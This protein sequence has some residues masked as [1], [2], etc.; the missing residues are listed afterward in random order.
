MKYMV[1]S[2]ERPH[3]YPLYST[4]SDL[5]SFILYNDGDTEEPNQQL[6][7]E[8][9]SQDECPESGEATKMPN[10][11][12]EDF[13]A[14]FWSMDFDGA[15]NKEG[16]GAG[17]WLH[18]HQKGYSE[19]HSYKLNFHC[20]NNVA[21]YEALMLGLK[22]LKKVGAKQIMVRGDSELVVEQ[23]KGEYAAKHPRLR[24][25]RNAALD[26]LKC[27]NEVD[28]QAMP[29][30]Q[31]ILADGLATSAASCKI[32]FRKTRPYTVEVKCRLTVPDNIRYWQVFGNDDQIED[33]LQCKN[34]F[35]STNIDVENENVNKFELG[36]DSVNIVNTVDTENIVELG[37]SGEDEREA[38]VLQLKSNVLPRGLVPLEDLFDNDDVAKKPKIESH[39]QEVEDCNIGTGEEPKMIKLSKSLPP[40]QKL[41]YIE[42]F[43]EFS[44]VFAWGYEDLKAYDTSIIQHRIPIK[45][46]QK[47]FRQKLRRI[48]PKLLPLIE[49][50]IKKMYDAKIIV[51][52]RFSKWVSNLVPTCK[53]TGE[54]RLCID[55]RNLNKASLKDNYPL[56]KMDHLLQRVVGSSLISLLD[57]FSGYNQ[58]LVHPDDQEK[59]A[60][61]TPWGTFMYVKMPFGLMNMGATFQRAMDIAFIEELGKFIIV[62]LD[63]VTVFSQ[64]DDEH[65]RHLRRVFEKCRKFRISL[66]PKK[67]LFGLEEGKLLGHIISKEG[68]RIDPSRIE[69]ILKL[70]HPRN[71]KELQSFIGQI[72]FL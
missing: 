68:I 23:I 31:N 20:T 12:T 56:P 18:N 47:P 40:E 10:V 60:F 19:N 37:E 32:P 9:A 3:N 71:L 21:E 22:L 61:T 15:V 14:D 5:D 16:A 57:G 11:V 62:Y 26:A 59:T 17:V 48:N 52:L 30:G 46:N 25:Y 6:M 50:E 70:E 27:F 41:K 34:D 69:A 64:S 67:C 49:K 43:K 35:E 65:L 36:I 4:H 51:P 13:P 38:E 39:G 66:N 24:A 33:F 53:K 29:R 28:L 1:S 63:D 7:E 2:Q 44:D 8:V 54:I 58:V 42:L 45:E 55:F 72:N